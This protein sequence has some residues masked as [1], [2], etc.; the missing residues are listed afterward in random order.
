V[1]DEPSSG[2]DP[3]LLGRLHQLVGVVSGRLAVAVVE[4]QSPSPVRL[5]LVRASPDT[6][7]EIGSIT[8]GLTGMLLADAVGCD[9]LRLDTPVADIVPET[10]GSDLASV[11]LLELATHTS[12]LPRLPKR[13]TDVPRALAFAFLG[14]NPYRGG[15]ASVIDLAA[16]QPLRGRG[17]RRYS[18]LGG[19]LLGELVATAA[20]TDYP[21]LLSG[22]ILSP[23][24]MHGTWVSTKWQCAPWGRSPLGLPREPWVL[25]G[26][27]PAGG[28][29]ST[30]EDL[31]PLARAL[32]DGSAPG[33][34]AV[35]P[36]PGVTTDRPDRRT[37]LCWI[38][39]GPTGPAPAITW[40]NGGTGGYSAFL[41]LLPD[42]GRAVIAL[43]SVAG[44]SQRLQRIA[45]EVGSAA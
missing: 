33:S 20:S 19:A 29:V 6:P 7:F 24:G 17:G 42:L 21:T 27:T 12:G 34:A 8:K 3:D 25:G 39:D 32:L 38:V 1:A 4:S 36:L 31:V 43:Q 45:L 26:Y 2:G 23:L 41:G 13:G 15:P 11:T 22:R 18:N 16:R 5:A 28:L 9:H 30:V 40:H 10:E 35:Q 44:R 37:G 14:R